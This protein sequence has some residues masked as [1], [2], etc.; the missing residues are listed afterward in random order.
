[1]ATTNTTSTTRKPTKRQ[2]FEGLLTN[3]TLTQEQKDFIKHELE[4]LA[5]KNSADRKPTA[6]QTANEA[7]KTAILEG[8]EVNR[9]YTITEL[10]KEIPECADMTNQKVSALVRQLVDAGSVAKTVDKR[11]SYFSIAEVVE[12]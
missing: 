11:K 4:L 6:Q 5:K 8:M 10:I 3:S 12:E 1:M 2:M 7:V 9:L